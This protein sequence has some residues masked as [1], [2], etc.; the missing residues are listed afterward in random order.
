MSVVRTLAT[1]RWYS[2]KIDITGYKDVEKVLHDRYPANIM[3]PALR[4]L[5]PGHNEVSN[6][7]QNAVVNSNSFPSG[8]PVVFRNA[9]VLTY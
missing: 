4:L 5:Q 6:M 8:R 7:S 3:R 1:T 2:L 9:T